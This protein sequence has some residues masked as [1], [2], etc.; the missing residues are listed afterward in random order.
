VIGRN[1]RAR[2]LER[3]GI[4]SLI[5]NDWEGGVNGRRL[6]SFFPPAQLLPRLDFRGLGMM[7]PHQPMTELHRL[8]C[9]KDFSKID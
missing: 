1:L 7:T 6:G 4:I 8:L 5:I 3:C 9:E 2:N